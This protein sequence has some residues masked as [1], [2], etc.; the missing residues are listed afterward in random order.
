MELRF[1]GGHIREDVGMI[2]FQVIENRGPGPEV[3]KLGA[4]V[5]ESRVIFV[6]FND[7]KAGT[8]QSG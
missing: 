3:Y 5:E 8:A 4:L 6:G 7:K 1:D 2:K